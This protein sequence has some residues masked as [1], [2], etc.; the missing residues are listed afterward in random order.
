MGMK[1]GIISNQK[2]D[3]VDSAIFC[4][5]AASDPVG[6][7]KGT[8][9]AFDELLERTVFPG[10]F[11][12]IGKTDD[13]SDEYTHGI[14]RNGTGLTFVRF[15]WLFHGF[16]VTESVVLVPEFPVLYDEGLDDRKLISEEF[17]VL[18]A[19]DLVMN[20]LFQRNI[21]EDKENKP[22]DLLILFLN[23]SK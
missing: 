19:A 11:V 23:D 5:I 12:T 18:R 22:A 7:L 1:E 6:F 13:L 4:T 10:Y 16:S 15:D 17:L 2:R 21:S 3:A 9:Q 20:P 8:I 14:F